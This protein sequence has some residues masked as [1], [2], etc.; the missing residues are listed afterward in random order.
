LFC[1]NSK[2]YTGIFAIS[3]NGVVGWDLYEKS[4][5]NTDRMVEFLEKHITTQ[6][7]NKLHRPKRKMRQI[8]TY[9]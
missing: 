9:L 5:I 2:K 8:K 7:K 1:N 4:G 3:V 6:F